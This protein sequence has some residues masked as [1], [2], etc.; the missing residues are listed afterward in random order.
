MSIECASP[1][2]RPPARFPRLLGDNSSAA[3]STLFDPAIQRATITMS[4]GFPG[5]SS[6][7]SSLKPKQSVEEIEDPA[8]KHPQ[9]VPE[10]HLP[11][12]EHEKRL[13]L[14]FDVRILPI[15]ALMYL[16]NALDKGNLGNAKTN[17]M[18]HDLHF[19]DGQYNTILSVFFVPYVI[20][21][22]PVAFIGKRYG[23]S[24]VLPV[25][26]FVFGSMTLISA[27]VKNFGGMMATRWILGEST[28]NRRCIKR[29]S[30]GTQT[31][32][33]HGGVGVLS[34]GDLLLDDVLPP[35][36]ARS[37]FSHLLRRFEYRECLL[38]SSRVRCL[39]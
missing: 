19:K 15:L 4:A 12:F 6:R 10:S 18:E 2:E 35:G 20:F 38:W 27:G 24:R 9:D 22:A 14:K 13:V 33:R 17:G 16:A 32:R 29:G 25:L 11:T 30:S 28:C 37:S 26:M 34:A 23:P 3:E 36:R 5:A 1:P 8:A 7:T 21:S 31:L 39:S